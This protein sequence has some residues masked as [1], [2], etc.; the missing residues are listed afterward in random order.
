MR[1]HNDKRVTNVE[2]KAS[3]GHMTHVIVLHTALSEGYIVKY[4]FS[5]VLS[6]N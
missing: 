5:F 1:N 6:A 2:M 4:E 3:M